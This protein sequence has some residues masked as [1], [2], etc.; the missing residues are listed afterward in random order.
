MRRVAA[1]GSSQ[2]P[3][4]MYTSRLRFVQLGLR[5]T[6]QLRHH[7]ADLADVCLLLPASL[8]P[9]GVYFF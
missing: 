2:Q 1:D 3:M 4:S 7:A 8:S 5:Y 9:S 6:P